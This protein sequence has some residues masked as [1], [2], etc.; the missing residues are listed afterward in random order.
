MWALGFNTWTVVRYCDQPPPSQQVLS[1]PG[2]TGAGVRWHL[3]EPSWQE[4]ASHWKH[5][6]RL[7][8]AIDLQ[9]PSF[10]VCPSLQGGSVFQSYACWM[11]QTWEPPRELH[12]TLGCQSGLL[13]AALLQGSGKMS[14]CV[15]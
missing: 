14:S 4:R 7:F 6:P 3:A 2:A 10:S 5:Q 1:V 9:G 15:W 13:G 12:N 11:S 8:A